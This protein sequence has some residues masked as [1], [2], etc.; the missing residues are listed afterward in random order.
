ML[1]VLGKQ[2]RKTRISMK[3]RGTEERPRL[4]I[5]KT[6]SSMQAQI[7]NDLKRV[8][9]VGVSEKHLETK[10]TKTEKA[11]ALGLKLAEMAKKAKITKVMFD[12]GSNRYH[13]RV[14]AFADAARE[15]G[16]EF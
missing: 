11:K 2:R 7:I 10:G 15:G 9:I 12:K 5:S 6:N 13:G 14:K 3:V 1:H 4:S 8:T 16:L